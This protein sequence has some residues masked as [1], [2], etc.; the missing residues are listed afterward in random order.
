MK[1]NRRN[2]LRKI[3]AF[4]GVGLTTSIAGCTNPFGDEDEE[5]DSSDESSSDD[6]DSG[7][8]EVDEDGDNTDRTLQSVSV[9]IDRYFNT[10]SSANDVVENDE[11]P[12]NNWEQIKED[13]DDKKNQIDELGDDAPDIFD[14]VLEY[15]RLTAQFFEEL[16]PAIHEYDVMVEELEESEFD[17]ARRTGYSLINTYEGVKLNSHRARQV[18]N[19]VERD[20]MDDVDSVSYDRF[21]SL[22]SSTHRNANT[23]EASIDTITNISD[24]LYYY[25]GADSDINNNHFERAVDRYNE[26]ETR[27][28]RANSAVS[29]LQTWSREIQRFEWSRRG[30]QCET[31]IMREVTED[32]IISA[33]ESAQSQFE[34]SGSDAEYSNE[35]EEVREGQSYYNERCSSSNLDIVWPTF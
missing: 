11:I 12:D 20:E 33:T 17:D 34:R 13:I 30:T 15:C 18:L 28:S 21:S 5:T 16:R 29:D 24:A 31:R 8:G 32:W 6:D 22:S 7:S 23:Y 10:F 27:F 9:N 14:D 2:V 26:A 1:S 25:R 35:N 4:S 3:G 19:S